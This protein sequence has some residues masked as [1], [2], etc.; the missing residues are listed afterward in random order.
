[1]IRLPEYDLAV[2]T[3]I[4]EACAGPGHVVLELARENGTC[5]MHVWRTSLPLVKVASWPWR[6]EHGIVREMALGPSWGRHKTPV[7]HVLTTSELSTFDMDTGALLGTLED[8]TTAVCMDVSYTTNLLVLCIRRFLK[9]TQQLKMYNVEADTGSWQLHRTLELGSQVWVR[10]M[11]FG[12]TATELQLI[13]ASRHHLDP[14]PVPVLVQGSFLDIV[15]IR[16]H[17]APFSVKSMIPVGAAW[18]QCWEGSHRDQSSY[19]LVS[20][21]GETTELQDANAVVP[22]PGVGVL[23]FRKQGMNVSVWCPPDFLD[24]SR[25]S[26]LRTAWITAVV[27]SR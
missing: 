17:T 21:C 11:V 12:F 16:V 5:E 10:G 23:A 19:R 20:D 27:T 7:L 14:G 18:Y 4:C 13:V 8:A 6:W 3:K 1:M 24:M 2:P 9:T 25:M 22:L 26:A 15:P